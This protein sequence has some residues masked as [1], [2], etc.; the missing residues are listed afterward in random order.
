MMLWAVIVFKIKLT[1][2][3]NSFLPCYCGVEKVVTLTLMVLD[4]SCL[5][6][7]LSVVMII[8]LICLGKGNLGTNTE[9][10]RSERG[11][12]TVSAPPVKLLSVSIKNFWYTFF[13]VFFFHFFSEFLWSFEKSRVQEQEAM[14]HTE[15]NI[16]SLLELCSRVRRNR[17]EGSN[18][19][20]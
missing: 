18:R 14:T 8:F 10:W 6:L 3:H 4:W 5:F 19:H 11:K 20:R 9:S 7:D 2:A 15:E 1:L 13:F 16:I 17:R 12:L